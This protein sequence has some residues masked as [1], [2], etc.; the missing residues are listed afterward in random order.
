M[1]DT[2]TQIDWRTVQEHVVEQL[3]GD[4]RPATY[5]EMMDAL[6]AVHDDVPMGIL[7]QAV[8][9]GVLDKRGEGLDDAYTFNL[10][11]LDGAADAQTP[12]DIA[13]LDDGRHYAPAMVA[14]DQWVLRTM[15]N[16]DIKAPWVRGDLR[17]VKWGFDDEADGR[18][19][20]AP[21]TSFEEA[22]SWAD[23]SLTIELSTHDG[24]EV[25]DVAP[26][27][28]L[29]KHA[30]DPQTNITMVDLDDVRDPESGHII[31]EAEDIIAK[32]DSYAEIST[33][34]QGVHV[35]VFGTLPDWY[36]GGDL[37]TDLDSVERVVDEQPGIEI[38]ERRRHC[39]TTGDHLEGTP[40]DVE[41]AHDAIE[42]LVREHYS[43]GE[44]TAKDVMDELS[45]SDEGKEGSD[46]SSSGTP[47]SRY[48]G[49]EVDEYCTLSSPTYRVVGGQAQGPHPVHGSSGGS[50]YSRGGA[51]FTC[52]GDTW[53][54]HSKGH[55]SGGGALNLCAV[56]KG[57]LDCSDADDLDALEDEEYCEMCLE[58]REEVTLLS[59]DERPPYR[60][61]LGLAKAQ[62]LA[63]AGDDTF[64]AG[65]R[66]LLLDMWEGADPS[67]V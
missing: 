56:D 40:A 37:C 33:S 2:L 8:S 12:E 15:P 62:G 17:R 53:Y 16:K 28:I 46:Y 25:E 31:P 61:L 34:G 19:D 49:V 1:N 21:D 20:D 22:L 3:D 64:D 35:F 58:F 57:Y 52:R 51:N 55:D 48:F 26:S 36:R 10:G 39:V 4:I 30:D 11:A 67:M 47:S 5:D 18:R 43:D 6:E 59:D 45:R 65:L 29:S 13:T 27:Y 42:E 38:Y 32:L 41:G 63:G 9:G 54:C 44:L 50:T 23:S 14:R 7:E 66:D 24:E 60:A